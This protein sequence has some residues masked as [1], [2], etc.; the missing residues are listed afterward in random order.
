[1]KLILAVLA[2]INMGAPEP[3]D[4]DARRL[5]EEVVESQERN[6]ALQRRYAYVETVRTVNLRKNGTISR[7]KEET[8]AVTP[9]PGGEYRRL[10]GRNGRPLT[11]KEERKEEDKFQKYLEKQ[12]ELSPHELK[13]KENNLKKRVGRFESRIREALE[14]F[15]FTPLPDE[16]LSGRTV[17]VFQFVPRRDYEPHSRA[18]KILYRTEGTIWIDPVKNQIAKL[19]MRFR[20]DMKFLIGLFGRIS[21][22]TEAVAVQKHI[23]DEVWLFDHIEVFLKGRFYFLKKYNQRLRFTYTDYRK[24]T[25]STEEQVAHESRN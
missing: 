13:Q 21:K 25:V 17:K 9:A 24:Y 16:E 8:F 10:I 6:Q 15:E 7:S 4:D 2:T 5:L 20:E 19:H 3:R 1:M 12:L 23:G 11:S 22:G 14:V 18:T